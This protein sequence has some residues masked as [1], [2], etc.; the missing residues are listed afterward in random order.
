MI[1]WALEAFIEDISMKSYKLAEDN[2]DPKITPSHLKEIC[3]REPK[4]FS[5][6]KS[7]FSATPDLEIKYAKAQP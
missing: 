3:Q 6:L 4:S 5:F 2:K 1:A 7:Q